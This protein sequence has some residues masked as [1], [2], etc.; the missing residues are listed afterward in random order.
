MTTD[1]AKVHKIDGFPGAMVWATHDDPTTFYLTN[2]R[3]HNRSTRK[4]EAET[5][6]AA[7]KEAKDALA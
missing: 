7:I 3:G 4:L 1:R 6:E 2:S 5:A